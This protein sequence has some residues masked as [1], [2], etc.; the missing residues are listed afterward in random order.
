[1]AILKIAKMGHPVLLQ[2]AA[3][4]D[5]AAAPEVQALI[6]DMFET[7]EDAQGL[8]LAAPQVHVA[9]RLVVF[10][11]PGDEFETAR[12]HVLINPVI[13]PLSDD[14]HLGWEGCLSVPGLRG[15]VPRF[16][17]I[18]YTGLDETGASVDVIAQGM[19]ARVVQHECDHL[20]G[21]LY[22]MRM[23]DLADLVFESEWRHHLP[24]D[25]EDEDED[26]E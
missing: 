8:G 3:E 5:D 7:M 14:M 9:K 11:L 13:T 10:H 26:E 4:I 22:P 24:L 1:M 18:R 25:E 21:R 6:E 2:R 15:R 19:H 12:P 16:E 20:D 17:E 23:I